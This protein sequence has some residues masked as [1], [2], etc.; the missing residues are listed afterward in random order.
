MENVYDIANLSLLHTL[1]QLA[2][3]KHAAHGDREG[4]EV[5]QRPTIVESL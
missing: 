2:R 1:L 3:E 4:I 5:T